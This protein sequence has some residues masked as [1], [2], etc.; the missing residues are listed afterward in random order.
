MILGAR[1]VIGIG[2][3]KGGIGKSLIAVNLAAELASRDERVVLI[4][5]DLGGSNLHTCLGINQPKLTLSDFLEYRAEGI[6]DV[7]TP[8]GIPN[9]S[10]VSGAMNHLDAANPKHAEKMRLLRHIQELRVDRVILD[11]GAGTHLNV[12]DF[13]LVSDHGVLVLVPEPTSVENGYR[14]VKAAFWRRVRNVVSVFGFD[15]QLREVMSE[16]VFNSPVEVMAA[17]TARHPEAGHILASHLELFRPRLIVNQS[18]TPQDTAV[19]PAVVGAWRKFFGL[20]MDYLGHVPYDGELWRSAR[21]RKPMLV[22]GEGESGRCF[23]QI[24][25]RLAALESASGMRGKGI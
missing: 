22:T 3:G 19:G 9:L 4:D 18:R 15:E 6:E 20:E 21:A 24:A 16:R 23:A 5:A 8:T 1:R 12:L 7:L 10:L 11:L 14:F 2:G 17:F 25:D 13:F